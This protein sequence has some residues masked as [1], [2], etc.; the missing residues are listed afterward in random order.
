MPRS[1]F[2]QETEVHNS[3]TYDDTTAPTEAAYETNPL[4]LMADL[5]NLRSI[6]HELRDVRSSNWWAAL[7]A[8]STF[9]ADTPAARGVQ[10][11]N[12]DLWDLER[13]RFLRRR[14]VIGASVTAASA[15]AA[16]GSI[17]CDNTGAT[18]APAD[19]ET[20][21]LNDGVNAAVTFEFD[22]NSS[23]VE[24]TTLREVDITTA[25]DDDD[26]RDAIIAAVTGAPTLDITATSGG[27]GIVT[28]TNDKTGT[29]G[30]VVV[31]ETVASAL[32][33]VAGI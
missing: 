24:T 6:T 8:P 14:V 21:I 26:V 31:T 3:S 27:A 29:A 2:D 11:N 7:T 17:D 5:N 33:V 20:F 23:V 32:F 16:T 25:A 13:K 10:D 4:D 12:Q 18:V 9:A 30:N 1:L 28:L 22:T 19:T 15:V